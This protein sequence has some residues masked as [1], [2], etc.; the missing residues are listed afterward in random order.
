MN[1][2][3]TRLEIKLQNASDIRS[4]V[5]AASDFNVSGSI[6]GNRSK[7]SIASILGLFTLDMTQPHIIRVAQNE[8]SRVDEFV[9][10]LRE[11]NIDIQPV[12]V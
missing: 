11:K 7:V 2:N 1:D 9:E 12:S 6:E 10:A 5:Y 3:T 8:N 4:L